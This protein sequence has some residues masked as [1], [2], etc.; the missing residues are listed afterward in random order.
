MP[1]NTPYSN[2]VGLNSGKKKKK[3]QEE[4]NSDFENNNS[5]HKPWKM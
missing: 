4:E 3:R 2:N 1:F 5:L